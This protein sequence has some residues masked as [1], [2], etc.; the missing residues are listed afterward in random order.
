[1]SSSNGNGG[2]P[3]DEMGTHDSVEAGISNEVV[4]P[5]HPCP[6]CKVETKDTG[7]QGWRICSDCDKRVHIGLTEAE[8]F[9][10][11][12]EVA[13]Y[14]ARVQ[15]L[16]LMYQATD[17]ELTAALKTMRERGII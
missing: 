6:T 15:Q 2:G 8:H 17:K 3:K 4:P 9:A 5:A 11:L 12:E 14:K 13:G 7:V 1:M 10:L 16:T